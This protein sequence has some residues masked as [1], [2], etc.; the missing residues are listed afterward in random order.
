MGAVFIAASILISWQHHKNVLLQAKIDRLHGQPEQVQRLKQDNR[1]FSQQIA[2]AE[3]LE[4][5]LAITTFRP[6]SAST[7]GAPNRFS[8]PLNIK[9][10]SE[11][12]ISWENEHVTLEEF[13]N[14]LVASHAQNPASEAQFIVHG[15]PGAAFSATAY[16]VEQA[17]KAGFQNIV[18]NSATEPS[19]SDHWVTFIPASQGAEDKMPPMLP[20]VMVKP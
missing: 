11:G 10:T 16:V 12:Q 8:T 20:D 3:D 5:K 17:S 19:A 13:L 2:E 7:T 4:R 15:D 18:V 9:V 1:R 14:R 6:G